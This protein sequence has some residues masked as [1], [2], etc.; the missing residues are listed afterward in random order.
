MELNIKK[1]KKGE[2][3]MRC[4]A[5]K[6]DLKKEYHPCKVYDKFYGRHL[7]K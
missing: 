1:Y 7:F 3:C 4:G 6:K 2:D 5:S